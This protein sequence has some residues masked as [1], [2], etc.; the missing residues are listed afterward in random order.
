MYV[1]LRQHRALDSESVR[2]TVLEAAPSV[3]G[4]FPTT[5]AR[6]AL[7]RIRKRGVDVRLGAAVAEIAPGKLKAGVEP[8]GA[9]PASRCG[10][11]SR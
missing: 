6:R 7:D 11:H 3:L 5:L 1:A 9:D 10:R 2:W 8:G 4:Q